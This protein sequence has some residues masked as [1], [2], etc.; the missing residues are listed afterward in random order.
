MKG[1]GLRPFIRG[2]VFVAL[3]INLRGVAGD[4]THRYRAINMLSS[5]T[6]AFILSAM[7]LMGQQTY[8]RLGIEWL[9]VSVLAAAINTN[10]YVQ[11]Y[12]STA[13]ECG[14]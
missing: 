5:F 11:G 4:S 1:R 8:R 7:A 12:R 13:R 9:L 14:E 3:T 6:A 10:G 2:L